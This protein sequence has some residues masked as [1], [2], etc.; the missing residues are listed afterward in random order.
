M[1]VRES[2]CCGS[3]PA[4]PTPFGGARYSRQRDVL[5]R[6]VAARS[7]AFTVDD[8]AAEARASAGGPGTATVYRAI[9]AMVEAGYVEQVGERR[10]SALY[11]RC[12]ATGHHHHLVCTCCGAVAE[13]ACPVGD[14]ALRQ[15]ASQGFVVT[16]HEVTLTGLCA[17]CSSRMSGSGG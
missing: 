2:D 12:A 16:G 11:V 3:A 1:N 10:G 17:G 9:R 8:L 13:A 4:D 7:G 14:E 6:L 5:A 15:A